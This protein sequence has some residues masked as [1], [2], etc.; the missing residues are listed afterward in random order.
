MGGGKMA[1]EN[2]NG[3]G[4]SMCRLRNSQQIFRDLAHTIV[5][6]AREAS[7]DEASVRRFRA[8]ER[9]RRTTGIKIITAL[10]GLAGMALTPA[11]DL[12]EA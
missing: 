9:V 7:V 1:R 5:D 4:A 3:G 8:G 10:N 12:I 11:N 6:V 2:P